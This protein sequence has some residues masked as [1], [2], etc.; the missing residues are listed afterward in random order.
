MLVRIRTN[1]GA[2]IM[3]SGFPVPVWFPGFW[4]P[5]GARIRAPSA[6]DRENEHADRGETDVT[7]LQTFVP[8]FV[9][10]RPVK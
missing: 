5:Q 8:M 3:P 4:F 6:R 1:R 10:G 9:E 7:I 2:E